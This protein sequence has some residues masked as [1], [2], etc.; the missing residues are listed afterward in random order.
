ASDA[1][2][3]AAMGRIGEQVGHLDFLVHAL[4]YAPREALEGMYAATKRED[5]RVALDVS[6]YSLVAMAHA[7]LPLMKDRQASIVTLTYLGS[8]R[9]VQNYNVMGVA[10]AALEASVRYLVNDLGPQGARV[11]AISAGPIKTLA[12]S[13]VG[14]ISSMIKLHAERAPLRKPVE[15]GEVGDAALFL[16]SPLSRGI[17]GEVIYVDGGY[18]VLGV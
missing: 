7:A 4:A 1:E 9:V 18:H 10:K 5:F 12:S 6:A 2:I 11:N 14:G 3:Q 8:E 17:T 16:F 15:T 13:A